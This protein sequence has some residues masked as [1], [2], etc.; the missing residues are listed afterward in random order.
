MVQGRG[1]RTSAAE[2]QC[3]TMQEGCG[4]A[5]WKSG[6]KKKS[7]GD[8]K[9]MSPSSSGGKVEIRQMAH[10]SGQ[11]LNQGRRQENEHWTVQQHLRHSVPAYDAA[12][13]ACECCTF[14]SCEVLRIH[15]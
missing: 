14:C 10:M 9:K 5:R 4:P 12:C 1:K 15:Y 7:C 13:P 6:E 2:T 11:L 8:W 3:K